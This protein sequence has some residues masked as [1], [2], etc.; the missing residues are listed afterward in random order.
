M[1]QGDRRAQMRV[2]INRLKRWVLVDSFA[3]LQ[4]PSLRDE[5][6]ARSGA[7]TLL[8][9]TMEREPGRTVQEALLILEEGRSLV[10]PQQRSVPGDEAP[11]RYHVRDIE[12]EK[13]AGTPTRKEMMRHVVSGSVSTLPPPARVPHL[14][15]EDE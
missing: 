9:E 3:A 11:T 4:E 15:D 14:E 2:I 8:V 5:Y 7:V 13:I 6:L 12:A 10:D 1:V